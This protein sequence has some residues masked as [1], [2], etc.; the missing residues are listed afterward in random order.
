[1][2]GLE[3]DLA[4]GLAGSIVIASRDGRGGCVMVPSRRMSP[5]V[6]SAWISGTSSTLD[7]LCSSESKGPPSAS[8]PDT[9]S[10]HGSRGR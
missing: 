10:S 2:I 9:M 4:L 3:I 8:N 1:M 5:Y 7:D 6:K